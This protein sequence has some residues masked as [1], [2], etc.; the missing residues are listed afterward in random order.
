[1]TLNHDI[2]Q[3]YDWGKVEMLVSPHL[4][5]FLMTA[6]VMQGQS[7]NYHTGEA[8]SQAI[9]NVKDEQV[10]AILARILASNCD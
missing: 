6:L 8:A 4:D 1:M 10:R 5:D 2:C 3:C 9:A 7:A